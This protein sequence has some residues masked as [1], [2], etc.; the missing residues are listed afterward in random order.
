MNRFFTLFIFI[1]FS[2]IYSQEYISGQV[3][4]EQSTVVSSVLVINMRTDEKT[5]TN[6]EGNF[7]ISA[8]TGDEIRF[9]KEK[10]DRS[11]LHVSSSDFQK[12]LKILIV[13]TPIEIKEVE[14][15]PRLTGDLSK[16]SKSFNKRNKKQELQDEIGLPAPPE[17]PREKPAEVTKD[18]LLPVITGNL[19]LQAIYDV[20]SGKAKKQKRLYKYED[21]EELVAWVRKKIDDEYFINLG[22]PKE[23]IDNFINFSFAQN[24]HAMSYAKAENVSGFLIQ[25]EKP[26]VQYSERLKNKEK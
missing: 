25:I 6:T 19:N 14:I 1:I 10:F 11:S 21:Q 12:F 9:V 4:S 5:Y 26:A 24:P 15:R 17:K 3:V 7:T 2:K 13:K 23:E 8:K 18:I 16:D 22:I 20:A